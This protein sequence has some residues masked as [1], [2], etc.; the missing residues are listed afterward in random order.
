MKI[1]SGGPFG[2]LRLSVLSLF[3]ISATLQSSGQMKDS[4]VT[5]ISY[6]NIPKFS[7]SSFAIYQKSLHLGY[8]RVLNKNHS[9][10][11]FGGYNEFPKILNL[12]LTNTRITGTQ[13]KTG[14]SF[15]VEFRFYLPKENKDPAPHGVFLA[16]YVS[17]YNFGST[18]SLTHTD[19]SGSQ[20]AS[21]I[22][23]SQFINVGVELGYQFVLAKRFIID[24]EI[25]GPSF[26]Y[27]NFQAELNGHINGDPGETLQA[28][29]D[30]LKERMPLLSDLS[31][32]KKIYSSGKATQKFP[33]LGFRYA[34]SI[35]YAF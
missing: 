22:S 9:I 28:V 24:C 34:V 17:Y 25:F 33:F 23:R 21:L 7:I 10:Y 2:H 6:P 3:L 5:K 15:G 8:E 20:T 19:S 29:I 31:S 14:Y 30:A 1:L 35:G 18:N 16:P 13:N 26:T 32:G 12:N 4:P 11:V 27:Y